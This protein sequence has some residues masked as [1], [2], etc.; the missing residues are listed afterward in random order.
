MRVKLTKSRISAK[1]KAVEVEG[2][3]P[4]GHGLDGPAPR[5]ATPADLKGLD[6]PASKPSL[7]DLPHVALLL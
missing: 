3:A 4:S 7:H 2:F 1:K 5:Y 6:V